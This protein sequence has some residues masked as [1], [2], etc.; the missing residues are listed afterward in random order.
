MSPASAAEPVPGDACTTAGVY[1]QSGGPEVAGGRHFLVCD[2]TVWKSVVDYSATTGRVDVDIANDTGSCTAAKTGRLRYDDAGDEWEYCDG[3]DPWKPLGTGSSSAPDCTDNSSVTCTLDA[4]RSNDDPQFTAANIKDGINILGVTGSLVAT[5][6]SVVVDF[7]GPP[8]CPEIGDECSDGTIYAGLH[9]T[10]NE[11]LFAKP[12]DQGMHQWKTTLGTNDINPDSSIDGKLNHSNRGAGTFP[13]F[14]VCEGLSYG[15]HSDW[16]LPSRMELSYLWV[17]QETLEAAGN[18]TIVDVTHWSSTEYSIGTA[19]GSGFINAG[20]SYDNKDSTRRTL[21]IRR[22]AP[23]DA[24]ACVPNPLCPDVGDVCGDG[25]IFA[26]FMLYENASCTPLYVTDNNQSTSIAW[27]TVNGTNDITDPQ[28]HVD[29]QYSRDNRGGGTF[30]AF[31]LCE[32]N[33]YHG[34]SD[35][36]LPSRVEL[37]LLWLNRAAID[38]NAAGN[39]ATGYY[40]SSTERDNFGAYVIYFLLGLDASNNKNASGPVRCVRRD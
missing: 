31:E 10:L 17:V 25:S 23:P 4:T 14:A 13:A 11:W 40:W 3:S 5:S 32:D 19:W 21:C 36:Y 6:G 15:D 8:D 33:P 26:G 29:G 1:L 38:A 37:D 22:Q 30:P 20:Q 28:D 16:Y 24:T 34:K 2:G 18:I 9:P 7:K 39:F 27:K 12:T 35:W